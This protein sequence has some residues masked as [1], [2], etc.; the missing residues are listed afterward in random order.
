M[1]TVAERNARL[2]AL[3]TAVG[4]WA[5]KQ[6]KDLQDRVATAKK[7]LKGRTGSERLTSATTSAASALV[8]DE[9]DAFLLTT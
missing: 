7:V 2:D 1:A 9:I 3:E 4:Q 5:T 6:T 8:V